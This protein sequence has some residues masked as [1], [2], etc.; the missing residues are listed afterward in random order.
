MSDPQQ[1]M[2]PQQPQPPQQPQMYGQPQTFGQPQIYGQTPGSPGRG[3]GIVCLLAAL[4]IFAASVLTYFAI[5]SLPEDLMRQELERQDPQQL[6]ELEAAG[7]SPRTILQV[8]GGCCGAIVGL[9]GVVLLV[10]TPFLLSA[11]RG[12]TITAIVFSFLA[13]LGA[14][15]GMISS[16]NAFQEAAGLGAITVGAWLIVL[17]LLITLLILCF[18]LLGKVVAASEQRQAME[19]YAQQAAW[20]SYQQQQYQQQQ[21][22]QQQSQ[23]QSQQPPQS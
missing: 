14:I 16:L 19:A 8:T 20:Q 5:N 1:P 11:K 10:L 12:G 22:G 23:Q 18:R 17:G 15:V 21:Y 4:A 9:P 2:Q 7:F 13:I 6:A 3:A